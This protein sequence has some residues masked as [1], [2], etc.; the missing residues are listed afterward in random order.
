MK[1]LNEVESGLSAP[2]EGAAL[3][4]A[5]DKYIAKHRRMILVMRLFHSFNG[6]KG[7]DLAGGKAMEESIEQLLKQGEVQKA[8][9]WMDALCGRYALLSQPEQGRAVVR[10]MWQTSPEF[11]KERMSEMDFLNAV[12]Y[13]VVLLLLGIIGGIVLLCC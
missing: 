6:K 12:L 2:L 4:A 8:L 5:V 7:G 1:E 9:T 3:E 11:C 10:R 13:A